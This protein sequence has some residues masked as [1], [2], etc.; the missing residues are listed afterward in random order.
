[1]RYRDR[2]TSIPRGIL[3]GLVAGVAATVAMDQFLKLFSAG[4]LAVERVQKLAGGES[5]WQIANEQA[6]KQERAAEREDST[7]KVAHKIAEMTGNPILSREDK[8]K[9]GQA[10]HYTFGTL[11][12][13]VYG[14]ASEIFP[15]VAAGGGTAFGTLLFFGAD[16]VA[17]P[18]LRLASSPSE[19][20]AVDHLEHWA[21]HV[22]YGG[23][24][25][26]A[27]SL[28]RRLF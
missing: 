27:R 22:V 10:V 23:T 28:M 16:E 24:L 26:L 1:M 11:M 14:V 7:E 15:E 3:S 2:K 20:P 6:Q 5:S 12:G 18:A 21:A 25:E 13:V 9:A 19:T 17:V 8:K 4:Q